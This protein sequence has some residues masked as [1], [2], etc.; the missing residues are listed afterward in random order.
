[1]VGVSKKANSIWEV[2]LL[3]ECNLSDESHLVRENCTMFSSI[4]HLKLHSKDG[5]PLDFDTTAAK[6]PEI[7]KQIEYHENN[8]HATVKSLQQQL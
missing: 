8:W 5:T 7:R 1:M 6:F 4:T 3:T 2:C